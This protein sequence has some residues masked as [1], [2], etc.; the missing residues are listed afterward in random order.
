M[1]SASCNSALLSFEKV[2]VVQPCRPQAFGIGWNACGASMH[3]NSCSSGVNLKFAVFP[4]GASV[5]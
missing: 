2:A 5:T 4:S 1:L 3:L